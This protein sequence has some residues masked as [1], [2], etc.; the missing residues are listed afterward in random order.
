MSLDAQ[1]LV[2]VATV[3]GDDAAKRS[4]EKLEI[5]EEHDQGMPATCAG[6]GMLRQTWK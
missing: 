3:P 4:N 1:C 2:E 6:Y 5:V